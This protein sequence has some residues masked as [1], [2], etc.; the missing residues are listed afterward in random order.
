MS[1]VMRD[2]GEMLLTH[3]RQRFKDQVSPKG[4]PW[5]PLSPATLARKHK[6]KAKVLIEADSLYAN[7]TYHA[8][9]NVEIGSPSVY[10]N[11]H[12]FGVKQ[13]AFGKTKRGTP[14]PWD[15][16]PARPFIGI[17]TK[18]QNA[19]QA[20]IIDYIAECWT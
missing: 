13:G 10:A 4:I 16:L 19:I 11:T 7:L 5:T 8:G 20:I 1:P 9:R 18:D 3:T 12:Q 17:S 15:T 6:N 2:M 14:I